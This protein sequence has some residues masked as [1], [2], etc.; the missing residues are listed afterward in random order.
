MSISSSRGDH[1]PEDDRKEV[2]G[3]PLVVGYGEVR[4]GELDLDIFGIVAVDCRV[5]RE[6]GREGRGKSKAQRKRRYSLVERRQISE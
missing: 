1:A 6:G 4:W 2:G 3:A 5:S